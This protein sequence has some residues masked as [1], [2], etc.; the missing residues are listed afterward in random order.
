MVVHGR[1]KT[2]TIQVFLGSPSPHG[3]HSPYILG[4]TTRPGHVTCVLVWSKL[5]RRRLRKTLHKQTNKQTDRQTDRQTDTTNIMVTWPWTNITSFFYTSLTQSFALTC[6]TESHFLPVV[7]LGSSTWFL[8]RWCEMWLRNPIRWVDEKH[9]L[10]Q[11][12]KDTH[13]NHG[14]N[15]RGQSAAPCRWPPSVT[16]PHCIQHPARR[17]E[18]WYCCLTDRKLSTLR[19][20]L[21]PTPTVLRASLGRPFRTHWPDITLEKTGKANKNHDMCWHL[22]SCM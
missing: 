10:I 2:P 3:S 14:K 18:H 11:Y 20:I 12:S 7:A 13:F 6:S 4:D 17:S 5:D 15:Y 16:T 22:L 8:Q 9:L 21:Q 1:P 19:T